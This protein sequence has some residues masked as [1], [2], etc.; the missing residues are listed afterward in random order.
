MLATLLE[1]VGIAEGGV[2]MTPGAE[3]RVDGEA[4]KQQLPSATDEEEF[5]LL[6]MQVCVL[7]GLC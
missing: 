5:Q 1:L 4:K 3:E 2:W 6:M 7:H